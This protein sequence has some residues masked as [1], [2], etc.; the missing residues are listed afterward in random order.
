MP[1]IRHKHSSRHER[2]WEG[3]CPRLSCDATFDVAAEHAQSKIMV[4]TAL[5]DELRPLPRHVHGSYIVF[6]HGERGGE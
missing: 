6:D 2:V 5:V 4:L 1:P 3:D